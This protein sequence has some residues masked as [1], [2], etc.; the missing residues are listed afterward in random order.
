MKNDNK[1]VDF[2]IEYHGTVMRFV[3]VSDKARA[4]VETMDLESWQMLGNGFCVDHRVARDLASQL[5]ENG[6]VLH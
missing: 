6:F 5:Q 2:K 1:Y 4:E 3:P